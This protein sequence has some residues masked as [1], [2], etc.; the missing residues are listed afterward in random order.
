MPLTL[1]I[2]EG[3]AFGFISY[4]ILKLVCGKAKEVSWLIYLFSFLFILRYIFLR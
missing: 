1:S 2:T 4:S 3:I